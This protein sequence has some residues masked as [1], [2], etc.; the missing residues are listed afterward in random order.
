M[1]GRGLDEYASGYILGEGFCEHGNE[2]SVSVKCGEFSEQLNDC[3]FLTD[4]Q[5]YSGI[6]RRTQP[7]PDLQF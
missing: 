1:W 5:I 4:V 2:L 6:A 3:P 7:E